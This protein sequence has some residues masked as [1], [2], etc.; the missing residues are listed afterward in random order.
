MLVHCVAGNRRSAALV[1]AFL[2][3]ERGLTLDDAYNEVKA[4]RKGMELTEDIE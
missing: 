4:R 3:R 1:I 2:M